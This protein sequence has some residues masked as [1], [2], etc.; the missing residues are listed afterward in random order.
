MNMEKQQEIWKPIKGYENFYM[1]SDLGNVKSLDRTVMHGIRKRKGKVLTPQTNKN[2][3]YAQ[4]MLIV[5]CSYKLMYVHRLVAQAFVPNPH[6]MD[7]VTHIDGD[8]TNNA[9]TNLQWFNK[10]SNR[11]RN[12]KEN[13]QVR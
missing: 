13:K 12:G 7:C 4:V 9:A 6:N 8:Y 5:K 1:V 2:N 3:G 10:T 11:K